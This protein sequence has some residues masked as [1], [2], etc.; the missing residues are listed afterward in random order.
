MRCVEGIIKDGEKL[1]LVGQEL[2]SGALAGQVPGVGKLG[3]GPIGIGRQG[4]Q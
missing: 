4:A 3:V 2:Q 1:T